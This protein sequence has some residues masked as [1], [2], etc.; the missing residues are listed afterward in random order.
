MTFIAITKG[1]LGQKADKPERGTASARRHI[2]QVKRLPCIICGRPGPSDAHHC[3]CDRF[4]QRKASD[5]ETIPL[6]KECHQIGPMA[7]HNDKAGWVE[8]NGPDHGFLPRVA[9][10]LRA[11]DDGILGEWL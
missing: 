10:M 8:R 3:Y 9:D 1:P 11:E 2:E 7:I 4:G 5:F 6:C